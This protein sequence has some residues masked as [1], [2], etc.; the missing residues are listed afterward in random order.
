LSANERDFVVDSVV[1][2]EV[3]LGIFL[4]P[5]GRKRAQLE[6]R[7]EEVADQNEWLVWDA[8][9]SRHWARLVARLR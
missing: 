6:H 7:F 1:L 8:T 9:V 5:R 3:A 4:L 2:G